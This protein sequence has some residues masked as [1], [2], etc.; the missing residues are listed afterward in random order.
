[1][2]GRFANATTADQLKSS[3]KVQFPEV[4]GHNG[5]PRW[6]IS[7]G[8][9][10]EMVIQDGSN[11]RVVVMGHWGLENTWSTRPL[12]N[13]KGETMFEKRTFADAARSSR[14][15]VVATGWY[16]W[17]EKGKPYYIRYRDES[18]MAM[19]G[20]FW[21]KEENFYVVIVTR[22]AVGALREIH[23]RAPLLIGGD[24]LE[25]W[26]EPSTKQ[27]SIKELISDT[28]GEGLEFY[29]VS[30]SV[31]SVKVDQE[32]LTKRNNKHEES[33]G[34][35][36]GPQPMTSDSFDGTGIRV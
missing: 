10:I 31:G 19:G 9:D 2:C 28:S 36:R 24:G 12:I 15:L 30:A 11:K 14:C 13:A 33:M 8:T 16:E 35:Q 6:N 20:L 21:K 32:D 23:Q 4:A 22:G 26:C 18:P 1:M 5:R 34:K 7:P 25:Q 17:K 27:S 3:F 29:P